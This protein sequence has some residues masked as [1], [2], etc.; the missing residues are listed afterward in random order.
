MFVI[1]AVLLFKVFYTVLNSV[2]ILFILTGRCPY[3]WSV[4]REWYMEYI[5]ASTC[6]D[7]TS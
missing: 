7:A 1:K 2:A 5:V 4:Y 6:S 3:S